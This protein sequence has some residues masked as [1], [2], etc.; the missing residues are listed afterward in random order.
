MEDPLVCGD[1]IPS[2]YYSLDNRIELGEMA[3]LFLSKAGRTMFYCT[4][5]VYLY[6]DLSIYSAAVSKSLM[7]VIWWDYFLI[8]FNKHVLLVIL[9]EIIDLKIARVRDLKIRT[10]FK[11]S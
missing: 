6:G 1:S 8:I 4:L 5:C 11:L 7:D 9:Y 2:R 3:N 10:M